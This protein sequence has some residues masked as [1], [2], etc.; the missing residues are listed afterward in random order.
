MVLTY[1]ANGHTYEEAHKELGVAV[2]TIK[3]WKRLLN[4]TNSLDKR[5]LERS[6]R[7]FRADKVEKYVNEHPDALLQDIA[8]ECGGSVSGAFYACKREKL[9]FKKRALLYGAR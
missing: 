2:S 9:T 1:L 3:A 7:K 4:E 5:P 6:P 8:D